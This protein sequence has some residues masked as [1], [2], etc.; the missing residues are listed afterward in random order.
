MAS[1]KLNRLTKTFLN[2]LGKRIESIILEHRGYRSL[3]AF[4]LEFYDRIAK[5]TLYQVCD[6]KRDMKLST[7]INLAIALEIPIE[8]L[9]KGL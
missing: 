4:S 6:G 2:N 3:D 1:R 9:L 7:L 5:P 8:E